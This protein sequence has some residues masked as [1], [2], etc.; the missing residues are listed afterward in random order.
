MIR[1]INQSHIPECV[2]VIK[3]AFQTV[4]DEFGFTP[5]NAPRF[6]AFA[7]SEERL[8]WQFANEKRPMF[9]YFD[10]DKNV[11]YYSLTLPKD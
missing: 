1:K 9:A 2:S 8:L 6:T 7:I 5:E 10:G 4:A 3:R 11:V